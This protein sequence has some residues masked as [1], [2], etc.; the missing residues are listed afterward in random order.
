MDGSFLVYG[1]TLCIYLEGTYDMIFDV[2]IM[3]GLGTW[4]WSRSISMSEF[5]NLPI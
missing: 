5:L 3:V 2:G 1:F 4:V